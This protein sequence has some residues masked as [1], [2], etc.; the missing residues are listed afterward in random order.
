[1]IYKGYTA[2]IHYSDDDDCLVGRVIGIRHI[3]S[4]HGSSVEEMRQAFKEA[5]DF[6]L[7]TEA[8]PEKPFS[9]KFNVRISSERHAIAVQ[10]AEARGMSLNQFVDDAIGK[11]IGSVQGGT[12]NTVLFIGQLLPPSPYFRPVILRNVYLEGSPTEA[13][14]SG[15]MPILPQ[16]FTMRSKPQYG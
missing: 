10:M 2:K 15:K 1:M 8:K 13:N 5:I 12:S 14:T 7:A 4:F 11:A 9:G 16:P 3:I 6:Y